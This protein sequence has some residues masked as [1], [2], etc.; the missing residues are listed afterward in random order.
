[1]GAGPWREGEATTQLQL[2][3]ALAWLALAAPL[4]SPRAFLASN[5]A[6]AA[7]AFPAPSTSAQM[8]I[9]RA[10]LEE[11]RLKLMSKQAEVRKAVEQQQEEI[12]QASAR[13][14]GGGGGP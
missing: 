13:L 2:A 11:L 9:G 4:R 1:M 14:G 3:V 5:L 10:A 6:A 7:A 8:P 12:L